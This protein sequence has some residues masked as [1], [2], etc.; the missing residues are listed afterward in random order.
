MRCKI[1]DVVQRVLHHAAHPAVVAR[2]GDQQAVCSANGL[3]QSQGLR[4]PIR[5]FGVV[6][7]E[8]E[9]TSGHGGHV[10]TGLLG[11]AGGEPHRA[12]AGGIRPRATADRDD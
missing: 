5:G 6:D 3:D 2:A 9:F 4:C 11:A 12:L 10:S 8:H 7:R 1:F